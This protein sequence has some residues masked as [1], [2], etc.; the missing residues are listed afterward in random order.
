MFSIV[1]ARAGT[2]GVSGS[3]STAACR[4][5]QLLANITAAKQIRL[6]EALL[7]GPM[8]VY[9]SPYSAVVTGALDLMTE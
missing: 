2:V 9:L 5:C 7:R 6:T 8:S 3:T 4:N 1:R